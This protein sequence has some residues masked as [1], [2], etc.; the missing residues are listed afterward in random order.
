MQRHFCVCQEDL[1][2]EFEELLPK[3]TR[4]FGSVFRFVR[5]EATRNDFIAEGVALAWKWYVRLK[6]QGKEP[7][8]FVTTLARYAARAVRS[9]RTVC[10]QQKSKDVLSLTARIKYGIGVVQFASRIPTEE[11][12]R[13]AP[14][15][16]ENLIYEQHV[17]DDT[18]TPIPD[19]VAFRLDWSVF[20]GTLT[21]RDRNIAAFLALGHQAT[22]AAHEFNLS[23]GRISQVRKDW[24]RRWCEFHIAR[25]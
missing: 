1:K 7:A 6:Q 24:Q 12:R 22:E 16:D 15:P 23:L 2:D 25:G 20:L 8:E 19:Q 3:L 9:G 10:G 11:K 17:T 14:I 13:P 18:L 21:P 5:C 4:Y